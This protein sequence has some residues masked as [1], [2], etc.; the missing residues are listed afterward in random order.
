MI[1]DDEVAI[2]SEM[3]DEQKA[4]LRLLE[5]ARMLTGLAHHGQKRKYTGEGYI[6]HARNV[7]F[8]VENVTEDVE[9]IA[10]AWLHDAVE[11]TWANFEII[12]AVCGPRVSSLVY[13]VTPIPVWEVSRSAKA[14]LNLEALEKASPPAQTIK[15][16]DIIDNLSTIVEHDPEFAKIYLPEKAE[17]LR[18][19]TKGNPELR[20]AAIKTYE[21]ARAD[22][23]PGLP[24]IFPEVV[25]VPEAVA[26]QPVVAKRRGR[27]RKNAATG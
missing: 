6:N 20:L 5:R 17:Q 16:A 19:L 12:E 24:S 3:T 15:L 22:L 18:V 27:P 9:V 11:Q 23:F 1:G 14:M 10:A 13:E 4:R 7:A 21:K 2:V 25:T 8:Y 26:E